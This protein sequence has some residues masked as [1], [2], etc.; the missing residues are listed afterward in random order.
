[1]KNL[2]AVI[3]IALVLVGL[4]FA[5]G[6]INTPPAMPTSP[7]ASQVRKQFA[8]NVKKITHASA[9]VPKS[10]NVSA[11]GPDATLYTVTGFP[12]SIC[13]NTILKRDGLV[14]KLLIG[15]FT[16]LD[17][18]E[19][20]VRWIFDLAAYQ[21]ASGVRSANT[22]IAA[23]P[24][25]DSLPSYEQPTTVSASAQRSLDDAKKTSQDSD[26][27]AKQGFSDLRTNSAAV[28][29]ACDSGS[30]AA[31]TDALT[32][33]AEDAQANANAQVQAL[34]DNAQRAVDDINAGIDEEEAD[35]ASD[36]D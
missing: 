17:C 14:A 1:M 30:A 11:E 6:L 25:I 7:Y 27:L 2:I 22:V 35:E 34:Q 12:L 28:A 20:N 16:R 36:P 29:A 10:C 24:S 15:G 13:A 33:M 4:A 21:A 18:V 19:G 5:Q 8:E 3:S 9:K 26:R 23:A 31:C 32:K